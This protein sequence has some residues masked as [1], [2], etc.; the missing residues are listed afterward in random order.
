MDLFIG[1]LPLSMTAKKP[2]E[3]IKIIFCDSLIPPVLAAVPR[4]LFFVGRTHC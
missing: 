4:N 2:G 1:I 3:F